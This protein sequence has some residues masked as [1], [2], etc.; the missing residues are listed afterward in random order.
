MK[1]IP[2]MTARSTVFSGLRAG[3]SCRRQIATDSIASDLLVPGTPRHRHAPGWLRLLIHLDDI[4]LRIAGVLLQV[5]YRGGVVRLALREC[6][7]EHWL[8]VLHFCEMDVED[9]VMRLRIERHASAWRVYADSAL[10]RL[11]HLLPIERACFF[12]A[13]GPEQ[14]ALVA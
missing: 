2:T 10:E 7:D 14:H 8:L 9:G 6:L 13:G 11:N 1:S 5:A 4:L 3:G 12:D